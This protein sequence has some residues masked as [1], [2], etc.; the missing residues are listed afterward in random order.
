MR[1]Y[2]LRPQILQSL[3]VGVVAFLLGAGAWFVLWPYSQKSMTALGAGVLAALFCGSASWMRSRD[4][5]WEAA[6]LRIEP[7]LSPSRVRRNRESKKAAKSVRRAEKR[8]APKES[9]GT[10][11]EQGKIDPDAPQ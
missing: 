11:N 5:T 6:N 7:I 1:K 8:Q 2:R 9:S 3:A 4:D 10:E